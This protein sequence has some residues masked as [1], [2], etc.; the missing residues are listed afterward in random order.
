MRRHTHKKALIICCCYSSV[1]EEERVKC[2]KKKKNLSQNLSDK[3]RKLKMSINS[4]RPFLP[5]VVE[6]SGKRRGI[7]DKPEI[8]LN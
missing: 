4:F 7:P 6:Q 5:V 2:R 1:R 8:F 3:K